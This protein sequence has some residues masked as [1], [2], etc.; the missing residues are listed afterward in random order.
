MDHCIVIKKAT[1][2]KGIFL[3]KF[4]NF[5]NIEQRD[6]LFKFWNWIHNITLN[7]NISAS[8]QD[9]KILL[10]RFWAIYVRIMHAKFQPSSFKTVGEDRGDIQSDAHVTSRHFASIPIQV[11]NSMIQEFHQKKDFCGCNV[12]SKHGNLRGMDSNPCTSKSRLKQKC[13]IYLKWHSL[14][15]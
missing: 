13:K 12:W 9:I 1:C 15:D 14:Q 2:M 3:F 5:L 11:S 4:W 6:F 10:H 7:N 8:R